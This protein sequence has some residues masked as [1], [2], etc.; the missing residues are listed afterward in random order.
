MNKKVIFV[1]TLILITSLCLFAGRKEKEELWRKAIT[2]KNLPLKYQYLKDY[3]AQYGQK[4]DKFH[5]YLYLNL[6]DTA[7]K[8]KKW[9]EAIQFGEKA[10][11]FA[12]IDGSNRLQI[13]LSL[14]NSYKITKK[15]MDK[16]FEYAGLVVELCNELIG[17]QQ[18][19]EQ[20][21]EQKK[22]FIANYK[23]FYMAPSLRI[24]TQILFSKGKDNP[25]ILKQAVG[26][27]SEAFKTDESQRS[28][29][30]VF[31]ISTNLYRKK[32]NDDAIKALTLILNAEKP[33]YKH[34]YLLANLYNRKKDKANTTKYFE[35]AYK[36]ERK[37]S[38][39]MKIGRLLHKTSPEK[40]IKFFAD[41]FVMSNFDKSGEAFKYMEQLYFNQIAKDKTPEEKEKGFQ[42]L[43]NAAR[44]RFGKTKAPAET[45]PAEEG[46]AQTES[47][48]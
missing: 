19:S 10:L 23:T 20:D 12:E 44:A 45:A 39:A 48:S 8:L 3:E 40:G 2:E 26:K 27:A 22:K 24:Q 42:A 17:K 25:E 36:V 16:A 33:E 5:K 9:D 7:F 11:T 18:A 1:I 4:K 34:A 41:A 32:L 31:S 29:D 15:D 43:I 46:A 37:K 47:E 35:M 6:A 28:R 13:Y 30:L 21:E 38:L 14:A